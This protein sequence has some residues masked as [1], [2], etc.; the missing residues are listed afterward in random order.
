M[1]RQLHIPIGGARDDALAVG[2]KRE[3]RDGCRMP[4]NECA[5]RGARHS[6]EQAELGG[7]GGEQRAVGRDGQP[8]LRV[9]KVR[10]LTAREKQQRGGGVF[11]YIRERVRE[12]ARWSQGNIEV[13]S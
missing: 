13:A 4:A 3:L 10:P 2:G 12:G 5:H 6:V 1:A 9:L 7:R 8:V 11:A